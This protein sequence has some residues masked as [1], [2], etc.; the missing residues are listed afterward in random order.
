MTVLVSRPAP[1]DQLPLRS[2][3]NK[4]IPFNATRPGHPYGENSYLDA[5]AARRL[6]YA[7]FLPAKR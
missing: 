5:G 6:S 3:R 1:I 2:P 4:T 7:D